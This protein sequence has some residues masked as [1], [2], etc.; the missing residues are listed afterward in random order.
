MIIDAYCHVFPKRFFE[1]VFATRGKLEN[2]GKRMQ[3]IPMLVDLDRRFA[4]MDKFGDYRQIISLPN[5]PLEEIA[6]AAEGARLARL[7]N[8]G[9][10]EL[11]NRFPERFPGFVAQVS[12]NDVVSALD[13]IDRAIGELG[14]R[15]IQIFTNVA[16]RPLDDPEF[17]PIFEKMANYDLPIWLHPARTA[18]MTDYASESQSRYEM[19]WCFGWPYETSVA[20]SRLVFSGVF[21]R[22][23]NLKIITHHLGG[24]I[25][26]FDGR[27]GPGMEVLGSR[28]T[29]EDYS[30]V[31]PS[32]RRPHIEYFKQFYADTALFGSSTGLSSGLDFFGMDNVV[33]ASDTPFGPVGKSIEALD[34][35]NLSGEAYGKIRRANIE[36]LL[37]LDLK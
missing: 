17:A 1:E 36:R 27:V 34:Q 5:P 11:C 28:T 25:P 30:N 9:L 2:M 37:K 3:S 23:P 31:L 26:Y 7:G 20:M 14:A 16:G 24:M 6:D 4:E 12:L 10:A 33:F 19:W 32:L 35:L 18:A 22:H 8:D 21:D 15:G 13:E 29:S